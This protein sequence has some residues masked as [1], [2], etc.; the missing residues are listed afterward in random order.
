MSCGTFHGGLNQIPSI[1][2]CNSGLCLSL[3]SW[4][5]MTRVEKTGRLSRYITSRS[6]ATFTQ[7]RSAG[8]GRGS[9]RSRSRFTSISRLRL[10]GVTPP[11]EPP[12]GK[13]CNARR[14]SR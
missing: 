9:Q 10:V 11:A 8:S 7:T 13:F 6:S 2:V 4:P 5:T 3:S 14:S 12:E 1:V